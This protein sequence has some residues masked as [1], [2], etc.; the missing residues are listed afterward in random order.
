MGLRA[1]IACRNNGT[2]ASAARCERQSGQSN[3]KETAKGHLSSLHEKCKAAS[4]K[5]LAHWRP[6]L[7]AL[8]FPTSPTLAHITLTRPVRAREFHAVGKRRES[9]EPPVYW[10]YQASTRWPQIGAR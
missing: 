5:E 6:T 4:S 7:Y 8:Q 3:E 9:S 10:L 1:C 2:G